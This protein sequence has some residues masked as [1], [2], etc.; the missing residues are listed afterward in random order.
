MCTI[1]EPVAIV[2]FAEPGTLRSPSGSR[3]SVITGTRV[4]RAA[5]R[6]PSG[7]CSRALTESALVSVRRLIRALEVR[8][9]VREHTVGALP[10]RHDPRVHHPDG[11]LHE[12]AADAVAHLTRDV[13]VGRERHLDAGDAV[14]AGSDARIEVTV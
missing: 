8:V 12:R 7:R 4:S 1:R 6:D 2:T 14:R 9:V 3:R 13:A 5:R 11:L 10:R